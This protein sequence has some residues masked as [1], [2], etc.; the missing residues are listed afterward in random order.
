MTDRDCSG[1]SCGV[2]HPGG[3]SKHGFGG[4]RKVF[5]AELSMPQDGKTDGTSPNMPAWWMLNAQLSRVSQYAQDKN[6]KCWPECGEFDLLEV[7]SPGDTRCSSFLHTVQSNTGGDSNYIERPVGAPVKVAVV[8]DNNQATIQKLDPFFE[9]SKNL[10]G[11]EI[12]AIVEGEGNGLV[13]Q[14]GTSLFA[15]P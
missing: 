10:D 6:C 1:N 12:Q 15:L 13:N 11:A 2:T 7:H 14:L 3:I 5:F 9:F 4:A 8:M